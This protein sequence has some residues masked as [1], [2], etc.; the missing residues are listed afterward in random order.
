MLATTNSNDTPS[1]GRMSYHEFYRDDFEPREHY[2]P[3]WEHI[4]KTGQS[5]LADKA[6][7]E[8]AVG[9][10]AGQLDGEDQHAQ[11][12]QDCDGPRRHC[13]ELSCLHRA[14]FGH[15]SLVLRIRPSGR[16]HLSDRM[17]SFVSSFTGLGC[18]QDARLG[19]RRGRFL[20]G[21]HGNFLGLLIPPSIAL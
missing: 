14:R 16:A 9:R 4:R 12:D 3:L 15:T 5:S 20:A 7:Q 17:P 6:A 13:G 11:R 2:R 10:V 21:A 19:K 18:L 1:S 8:G